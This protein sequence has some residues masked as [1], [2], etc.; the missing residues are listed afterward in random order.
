MGT[1]IGREQPSRNRW[2]LTELQASSIAGLRHADFLP[3]MVSGEDVGIRHDD[4]ES[5]T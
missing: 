4:E 2:S 3:A 1:A 5:L